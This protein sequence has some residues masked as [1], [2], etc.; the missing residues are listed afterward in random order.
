MRVEDLRCFIPVGG[1]ALRLR[2]LTHDVS[3]PCIRFLNRPLIEFALCELAEQGVKNFIFGEYGYTN[4]TN[5]FDQYGEGVGFSAKYKIEPRVHI[6]HQP[7]LDD[8]GSAD[9]YRLNVEYYDVQDPVIVVQ[10]DNI[11]RID[12]Q[13]F[14]RKHE[15]KGAMMTIALF[16]VD[17]VEGFGV[18]DLDSDMRI[19]KF[20]EKPP[21]NEAPSNYINAGIYLLS[22]EIRNEVKSEAVMK[23]MK[24]RKRLDFGYDF[25]PYLVDKGIPVY[26]YELKVWYDIGSP[27]SY[28]KAM[29]DILYGA[30]NIRIVEERLFPGKNI[31]IQGFSKEAL[32]VKNDTLRRCIE[33]RLSIEGADLIGRHTRIGDYSRI[34]DSN[35]DNF[36]IIGEHVNIESSAIMDAVKIGDYANISNSIVGRKVVIESNRQN[37]TH[38]EGVSVIGNAVR[39]GEGCRLI[40]TKVNPGLIIPPRMTY[41]NKFIQSYEDIVKLAE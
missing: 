22:P 3:K 15:E 27:E 12:L 11:F 20:V 6:K 30:I 40:S 7:N 36:C 24:E 23:I 1:K 41:I 9:S 38:I 17:N 13:D 33:G 29:K 16:K 19:K 5:L 28:L 2:P 10:G 21:P 31:W 8:C 37:P 32:K 26:G 39:I 34:I 25:I 18:V 4:Y 35:I 14:I